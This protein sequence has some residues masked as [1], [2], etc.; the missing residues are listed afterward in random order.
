MTNPIG[1]CDTTWNPVVGCTAVAP[2]CADCYAATLAATRLRHRPEYAGL[3]TYTKGIARWTGQVRRLPAR[4]TEPLSWRKPRRCFVCDMGD[5]FDEDVPFEFIDRVFAVM[6]L[7]PH[8]TYQLLTKRP[9]R[10]AEYLSAGGSYSSM[11]QWWCDAGR[12]IRKCVD[13]IAEGR[14]G[15]GAWRENWNSVFPLPKVWLGTS[16]STQ[17]DAHANVPHLLR[18]PARVR[19]LSV[20]P[21]LERILLDD[22]NMVA[23]ETY[24]DYLRGRRGCTS[25]A[26][27]VRPEDTTAIHWVIVGGESGPKARPCDEEWIKS[28]VEQCRAAAVPCFV[29][30]FGSQMRLNSRKGNDPAEWPEWARVRQFPREANP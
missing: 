24:H 13:Q 29:K 3:A 12:R 26:V 8:I 4:L 28:I 14:S 6:A 7:T 11:G 21:L 9:E 2:G 25:Q 18:C 27:A 16:I 5:L 23:D 19:F 30:Q 20:E 1:W 17:A 10:M 22:R 15:G